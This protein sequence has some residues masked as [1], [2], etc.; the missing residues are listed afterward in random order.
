MDAEELYSNLTWART[1]ARKSLAI[2]P[3]EV[4]RR[5]RAYAYCLREMRD[6]TWFYG[7]D[8]IPDWVPAN[9]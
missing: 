6:R 5:W 8:P 9:I 2:E 4:Q 7:D 3:S 1:G